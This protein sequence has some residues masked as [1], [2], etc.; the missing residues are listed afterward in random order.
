MEKVG[1]ESSESKQE[2][3]LHT[4]GKMSQIPSQTA[5]RAHS[6][7]PGNPLSPFQNTATTITPFSRTGTMTVTRCPLLSLAGQL[8]T[9][10]RLRIII[11]HPHNPSPSVNPRGILA[12]E[13]VVLLSWP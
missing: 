7:P 9:V 11:T 1:K 3:F 5:H 10:Q 12:A 4:N 13:C 8:L 2:H 6:I